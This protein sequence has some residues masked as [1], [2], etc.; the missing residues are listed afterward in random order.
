M[1]ETM[2]NMV[3]S[4]QFF[5]GWDGGSSVRLPASL[6]LTLLF[7]FCDEQT[8]YCGAGGRVPLSCHLESTALGYAL[9]YAHRE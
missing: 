7:G 5:Y 2:V 8:Y 6:F 1:K 4:N 9:A 3:S